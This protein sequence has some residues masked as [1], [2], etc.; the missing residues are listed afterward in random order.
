M[1]GVDTPV[2]RNAAK[3]KRL[4]QKG[5]RGRGGV[6][7]IEDIHSVIFF[8]LILFFSYFTKE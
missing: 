5:F 8:Q 3:Q 7:K 4:T 6:R 1:G 2:P